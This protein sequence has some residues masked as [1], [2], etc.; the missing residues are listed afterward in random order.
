MRCMAYMPISDAA[1]N[2]TQS[3]TSVGI[4]ALMRYI[5]TIAKSTLLMTILIITLTRSLILKVL[6]I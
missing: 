4:H 2:T 1:T 5:T 6:V 3:I